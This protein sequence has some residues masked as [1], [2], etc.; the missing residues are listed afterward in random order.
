M[1]S[2]RQIRHAEDQI[3]RYGRFAR[4]AYGRSI[5]LN[6]TGA[7]G[8]VLLWVLE[9]IAPGYLQRQDA[10]HHFYNIEVTNQS[11]DDAFM[12]G[13]KVLPNIQ[14]SKCVHQFRRD[15]QRDRI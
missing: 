8:R 12:D 11:A 9:R 2:S 5:M 1:S 3:K 10:M 6:P 7:P 13:L 4:H 14:R 15:S